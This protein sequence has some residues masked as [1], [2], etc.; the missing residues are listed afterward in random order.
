RAVDE[1][2]IGGAQRFCAKAQPRSDAGAEVF[3]NNVD[4]GGQLLRELQIGRLLQVERKALLAAIV[5]GEECAF[6]FFERTDVTIVVAGRRF[7]LD[8]LRAE[9]G[10]QRSAVGTCQN[11]RKVK[12][13]DPGKRPAHRQDPGMKAALCAHTVMAVRLVAKT[14]SGMSASRYGLRIGWPMRQ[15]NSVGSG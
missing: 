7:E 14:N 10:H 2:R 4:A 8:D 5:E 3:H 15:R 9:I 13:P 11:A 1:A 6:A 12:D